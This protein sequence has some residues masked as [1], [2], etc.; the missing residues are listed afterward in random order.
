MTNTLIQMAF[1]LK[2]KICIHNLHVLQMLHLRLRLHPTALPIS[3]HP[4][5]KDSAQIYESPPQLASVEV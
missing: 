2:N 1:H 3:K 4:L 5:I